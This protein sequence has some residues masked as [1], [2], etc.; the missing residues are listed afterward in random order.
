MNKNESCKLLLGKTKTARLRLFQSQK[1]DSFTLQ[2]YRTRTKYKNL[3][4]SFNFF[5][6]IDHKSLY[7]VQFLNRY[8]VLNN[9]KIDAFSCHKR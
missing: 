8:R 1:N 9:K 2:I 6:V 3:K 7:T 5:I 4:M